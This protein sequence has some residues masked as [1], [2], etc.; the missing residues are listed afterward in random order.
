[1]PFPYPLMVVDCDYKKDAD[2]DGS[3]A[4][5]RAR[6]M[7]RLIRDGWAVYWSSS[8]QGFHA[9]GAVKADQMLSIPGGH[10]KGLE[11]G[12]SKRLGLWS[13][14]SQSKDNQPPP[15][16]VA[17][18]LKL[19]VFLPGALH[20]VAA[21]LDRPGDG[22]A[23]DQSERM[24]PLTDGWD[25]LLALL[26]EMNAEGLEHADI[27]AAAG[28][29]TGAV[30]A[31]ETET[32]RVVAGEKETAPGV[33][34]IAGDVD[35]G[36][37][38][39]PPPPA[40]PAL[41]LRCGR[42]EAR[43]DWPDDWR[44]NADGLCEVC[45][46]IPLVPRIP[47]ETLERMIAPPQPLPGCDDWAGCDDPHC[48]ECF[49]TTATTAANAEDLRAAQFRL[50]YCLQREKRDVERDVERETKAA[51]DGPRCKVCG[52]TALGAETGKCKPC[53]CSIGFLSGRRPP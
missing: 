26:Q 4:A 50:A 43:G 27:E 8:W 21:H 31:G 28:I 19:D 29:E 5:F 14:G 36:V 6:L 23:Q 32:E 12:G 37:E 38:V 20:H 52:S 16:G 30:G 9:F 49:E 33:N 25:G 48:A 3:G 45:E 15:P 46:S 51:Y 13:D 2:D 1:M 10:S 11:V 53:G 39:A 42:P 34:G 22:A 44:V 7:A 17:H 41:C 35:R 18:G 47:A 24:L 40:L